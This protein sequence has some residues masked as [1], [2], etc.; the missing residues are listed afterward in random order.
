[1][2]KQGLKYHIDWHVKFLILQKYNLDGGK[3]IKTKTSK[4]VQV[5]KYSIIYIILTLVL[6]DF[7]FNL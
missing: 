7:F 3:I 2:F 5:S 4:K 1:M 6:F